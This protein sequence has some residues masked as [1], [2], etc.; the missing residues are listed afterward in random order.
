MRANPLFLLNQLLKMKPVLTLL[1]TLAIVACTIKA[2]PP[3][4]FKLVQQPVTLKSGLSF[5]LN[6]PENYHIAIAAEVTHRLRFLAKS[7]DGRLFAT[8]LYNRADT[9]LGRILIFDRWNPTTNHF[10]TTIEYLTKL[11]TPN[12][13]AFY[14]DRNKTYIYIAETGTLKRFEYEAGA[15]KPKDTGQV[16][17]RYPDY[18]LNYKYGGWHLTRSLVFRGNKLYVS[19]GSSCNA[20]IEKETVRAA[21]MEMNPDGTDQQ[22]YA[23]GLRNSVGLKWVN[24][25][26]WVTSMGR[27]LIGPDRPEDLMMPVT[28][29]AFYGW[30]FY[31]QYKGK[32]YADTTFKDS[33]RS[34]AVEEPPVAPVG[35]KAHSAP[36]GLEYFANFSD[37]VL[38][39][40]F[41]VC[42]HGSTSVWRQRGNAVVQIN[43]DGSYTEVINGFLQGKTEKERYGRPC[44]IMQWS[45]NAF[46]VTDDKNGVLYYVW[47]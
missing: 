28:R 38:N 11:R 13:I 27:D 17:A 5:N 37:P 24:D 47:K 3:A 30:P 6:I 15:N 35:F 22:V 23:S 40:S 33:T 45:G 20:C 36:L 19:I 10:D 41:L 7:P 43:K 2:Q 39:N 26:L 14:T 21:I 4:K 9:K 1:A 18:G 8:D 32:V 31:Y 29:N 44:D 34:A 42:L 25:K 16:I 46:F 12:Q